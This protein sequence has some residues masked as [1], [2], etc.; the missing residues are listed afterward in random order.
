MD[1][2]SDNETLSLK[3]YYSYPELK[4]TGKKLGIIY[5]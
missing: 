2:Q 1:L 3:T 4:I 5:H